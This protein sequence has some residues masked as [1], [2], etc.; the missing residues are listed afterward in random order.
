[1]PRLYISLIL[2]HSL[3]PRA[4]PILIE[5]SAFGLSLTTEQVRGFVIGNMPVCEHQARVLLTDRWRIRE[6]AITSPVGANYGVQGPGKN[7]RTARQ[8]GH[9]RPCWKVRGSMT[10]VNNAILCAHVRCEY[11]QLCSPKR[12]AARS[13]QTA[14][15][16]FIAISDG[17]WGTSPI[18]VAE[19]W[20]LTLKHCIT[21]GAAWGTIAL[22]FYL[23]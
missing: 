3:V 20:K 6:R 9:R 16:C 22:Y 19:G 21:L 7:N 2:S 17:H 23:L 15:S 14:L 12:G 8:P 10:I 1:M 4:T 13:R 5:H 18:V 11:V